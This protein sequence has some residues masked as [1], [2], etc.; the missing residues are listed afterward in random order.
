MSHEEGGIQQACFYNYAAAQAFIIRMHVKMLNITAVN[1]R[2]TVNG[3]FTGQKRDAFQQSS[4]Q[5]RGA[6]RKYGKCHK[7]IPPKASMGSVRFR[8]TMFH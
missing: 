2:H 7:L 8:M 5:I 6:V 3:V 1:T 4:R